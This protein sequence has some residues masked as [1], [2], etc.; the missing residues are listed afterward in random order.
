M[1]LTVCLLTCDRRQSLCRARLPSHANTQWKPF[2]S[3]QIALTLRRPFTRSAPV[4]WGRFDA[5]FLLMHAPRCSAVR[6]GHPVSFWITIIIKE[7]AE[8]VNTTPLMGGC[9]GGGRCGAGHRMRC[10]APGAML[11]TQRLPCVKGAGS[12][13]ALTEGLMLSKS[14]IAKQY[15]TA[16]G[17]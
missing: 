12:A 13:R 15:S 14:K 5:P 9:F 7:C 3:R 8:I 10:W 2:G 16:P 11:G 6:G 1:E 4:T 17:F